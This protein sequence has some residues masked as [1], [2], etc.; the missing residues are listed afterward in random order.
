MTHDLQNEVVRLKEALRT[1]ADLQHHQ[2]VS[3]HDS[4]QQIAREALAHI[5]RKPDPKTEDHSGHDV[6]KCI[7]DETWYCWKCKRHYLTPPP[8]ET[9]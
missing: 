2:V 5:P 6:G 9:L 3:G 4:W 8:G 1:I 7:Y